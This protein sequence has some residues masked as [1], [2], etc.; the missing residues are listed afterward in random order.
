MCDG[1][2]GG[3]MYGGVLGCGDMRNFGM[4]IELEYSPY[5]I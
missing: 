3:F 2:R 4:K 5:L 1:M